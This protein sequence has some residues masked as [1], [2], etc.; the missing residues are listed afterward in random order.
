MVVRAAAVT[1]EVVAALAD[2]I[3][4]EA[5]GVVNV[6]LMAAVV[7]KTAVVALGVGIPRGTAQPKVVNAA[8]AVLPA[9]EP[10][11]RGGLA[12][13]PIVAILGLVAEVTE[14]EI[15]LPVVDLAADLV[16]DLAI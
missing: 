9:R 5:M 12:I 2:A 3:A 1:D 15:G 6:G 7:T 16:R 4:D 14:R 10:A 11:M 13:L 8:K